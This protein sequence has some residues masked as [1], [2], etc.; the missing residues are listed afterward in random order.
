MSARLEQEKATLQMMLNLYCR[1]HHQTEGELCP[2]CQ[3]LLKY[4]LARLDH[5]K[6]GENKTTCAK[7]PVHCYKPEMRQ[8]IKE[9]MGYSGPKMIYT[10]PV[11]AIRHLFDGL[12]S[13]GR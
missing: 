5:C 13:I 6:F 1:G 12:K 9:V 10:H 4:A 11:A 7:C 3:E 2:Q 8:K